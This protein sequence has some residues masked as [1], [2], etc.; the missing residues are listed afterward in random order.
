[1]PIGL[2][3]LRA[4]PLVWCG[5]IHVGMLIRPPTAVKDGRALTGCAS[6]CSNAGPMR[7]PL[8]VTVVLVFALSLPAA[9]LA[10]APKKTVTFMCAESELPRESLRRR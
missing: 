8:R 6:G 7:H 9:S 3:R 2:I 4:R 5:R 10:A 1:V